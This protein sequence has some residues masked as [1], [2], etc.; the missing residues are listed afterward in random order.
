[1]ATQAPERTENVIVSFTKGGSALV[2]ERPSEGEKPAD[3]QIQTDPRLGQRPIYTD[4]KDMPSLEQLI[5]EN[6]IAYAVFER[7]APRLSYYRVIAASAVGVA[8]STVGW[9][10]FV[11]ALD[12]SAIRANP[13]TALSLAL[14]GIVLLATLLIALYGPARSSKLR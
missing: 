13:Y 5:R 1:V 2:V 11:D 6:S 4:E 14:G 3:L 7:E 12:E 10:L 8:T 9:I